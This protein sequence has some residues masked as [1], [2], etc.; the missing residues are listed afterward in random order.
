MLI[1]F[2]VQNFRS[3]RDEQ[4]LSLVATKDKSLLDS[5]TIASGIKAAMDAATGRERGTAI[6]DEKVGLILLDEQIERQKKLVAN[7]RTPDEWH[8][9]RCSR[10]LGRCIRA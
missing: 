10:V 9:R 5:N 7:A 2:R 6:R 3:L 8:A 1:E 4:V